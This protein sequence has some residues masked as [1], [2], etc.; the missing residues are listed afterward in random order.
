ML[1]MVLF[2]DQSYPT[3]CEPMD[4]STPSFPVLH[5]LMEFAQTHVYWVNA[6]IQ[7]SHPLSP[8]YLALSL[9][10]NLILCHPLILPSVFPRIRVF[11]N[12]E[13]LFPSSGQSTGASAAGSVLPIYI[14]DWFPLGL[15]GLISLQSK[16]L[17]RVFSSIT[18]QKH[19]FFGTQPSLWSNSHIH[20]WLLEKP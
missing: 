20:M 17:S 1:L 15:A 12:E 10:Q 8:T 5:Y 11:S 6:A 4:C 19:W 2:S 16:G 7:P 13:K 18:V 3:L 14:Q 9:S